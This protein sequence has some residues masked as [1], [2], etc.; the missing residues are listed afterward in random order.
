MRFQLAGIRDAKRAITVHDKTGRPLSTVGYGPESVPRN[1][2]FSR[3][4]LVT[5]NTFY[6]EDEGTPAEM[7]LSPK[8]ARLE[9]PAPS[10]RDEVPGMAAPHRHPNRL[11]QRVR[12]GAQLGAPS[13]R[14]EGDRDQSDL[15]RGRQ[16]RLLSC[17][18]RERGQLQLFSERGSPPI[19]SWSRLPALW[20]NT[21]GPIRHPHG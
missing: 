10:S 8:A 2:P 20:R 18:A 5:F 1:G 9:D 6:R 3:S 19:G 13:R 7:I 11:P 14:R 16:A 15:R 21:S 4:V 17:E 12:R